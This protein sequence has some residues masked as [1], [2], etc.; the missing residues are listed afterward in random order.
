M[1]LLKTFFHSVFWTIAVLVALPTVFGE[2]NYSLTEFVFTLHGAFIVFSLVFLVLFEINSSKKMQGKVAD[3]I[4]HE[5]KDQ[6]DS[7]HV[8]HNAHEE[9]HGGN[10]HDEGKGHE[11]E[12][13]I[14]SNES[15]EEHSED[16]REEGYG[17]EGHEAL[18]HNEGHGGH[19]GNGGHG[20]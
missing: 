7:S 1:V 4:G 12:G 14:E 2:S 20:H 6:S 16:K 15:H 19:G 5:S 17:A 10:G 9:G 8:S 18:E 3:A 11:E 13:H